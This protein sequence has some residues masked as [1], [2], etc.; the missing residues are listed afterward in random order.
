MINIVMDDRQRGWI[1]GHM[2][3]AI[4]SQIPE[5]VQ[6]Q[7]SERPEEGYDVLN[8][9][10]PYHAYRGKTAGLDVVFCTHPEDVELFYQSATE[11]NHVVVMCSKYRR[12]LIARGIQPDKIS[13]VF[14]G[15][16]SVFLDRRLRVFIPSRMAANEMYAKR[17]GVN[18]WRAIAAMSDRYNVI[19]SQGTMTKDEVMHWYYWCHCVLITAT[20]EGGPMGAVEGIAMDKPVVM[21]HDVGL[22]DDIGM[23]GLM[24]TAGDVDSCMRALDVVADRRPK[25]SIM[26]WPEYGQEINAVFARLMEKQ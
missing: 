5:G 14:P 23:Y 8:Y 10:M 13:L 4:T 19:C 9:Y 17:K 26:S 2:V 12:E 21:P 18:L 16:D 7:V 11:A 24:Y 20:V 3:D 6:W 15:V 22:C 25:P 1:L